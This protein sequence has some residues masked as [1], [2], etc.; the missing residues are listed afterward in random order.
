MFLP[1]IFFFPLSTHS[2]SYNTHL[3]ESN[4]LKVQRAFLPFLQSVLDPLIINSLCR[5]VMSLWSQFCSCSQ[6]CFNV[7]KYT[8]TQTVNFLE[9]LSFL[10]PAGKSGLF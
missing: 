8:G 10:K 5:I 1:F 4:R 2:C 3:V 7:M 6:K 9:G